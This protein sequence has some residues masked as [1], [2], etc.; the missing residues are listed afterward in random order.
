MLLFLKGVRNAFSVIGADVAKCE[1]AMDKV[2]F[3]VMML[4]SVGVFADSTGVCT[5]PGDCTATTVLDKP[6]QLCVNA[7]FGCTYVYYVQE[8][9]RGEGAAWFALA[10]STVQGYPVI[11]SAGPCLLN[12]DCPNIYRQAYDALRMNALAVNRA[13]RFISSD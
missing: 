7:E 4:F 10:Q 13:M 11:G 2:L 5:G 6:T 9:Y 8:D 12:E 3:A 1:V